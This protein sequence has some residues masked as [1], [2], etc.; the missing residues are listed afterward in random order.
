MCGCAKEDEA[1]IPAQSWRN[2]HL[3]RVD[4]DIEIRFT[5]RIMARDAQSLFRYFTDEVVLRADAVNSPE[6][7][8]KIGDLH[9]FSGKIKCEHRRFKIRI[10]LY[11]RFCKSA[12]L[13][14]L[15]P[16]QMVDKL[17][18]PSH[19]LL[20]SELSVQLAGTRQP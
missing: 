12:L 16:A 19:D 4:E 6:F 7:V 17:I 11:R 1:R 15:T 20:D 3:Q 18:L 2:H 10:L 13:F 14:H 5:Q 8:S 9:A